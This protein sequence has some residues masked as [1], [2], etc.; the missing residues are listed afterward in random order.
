V[1]TPII[2]RINRNMTNVTIALVL[3]TGGE[4]Y[5]YKYVNNIVDSIREN[6]STS[7]RIVCITD[8]DIGLS[9]HIDEIIPFKHNWPKWW[10]KIELFRPDIL[11]DGQIFFFDLDTFIVGCLDDII[12]YR[13]PF[14]GLRDFYNLEVM[15]SG[16]MS[17][18]GSRFT[19]IYDEFVKRPEHFMQVNEVAGDQAFIR[20]LVQS[21]QFFQDQFPNQIV[22][23]KVHCGNGDDKKVPSNA[24]VLCFHGKPKPHEINNDLRSYWKQ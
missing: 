4:Y 10:G 5:D 15:A 23:Y 14:C 18:Q 24:R 3:K 6:I 9:N 8:N 16:F 7:Y 11:Q 1:T 12:A 20:R 21:N 22:S 17:W 2:W 13:G 19:R